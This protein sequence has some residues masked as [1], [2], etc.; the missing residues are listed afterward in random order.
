MSVFAPASTEALR[1]SICARCPNYRFGICAACGCVLAL[2]V[3]L[4]AADCP[5]GKWPH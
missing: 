4:A 2:K 1:L 3:K 5:L